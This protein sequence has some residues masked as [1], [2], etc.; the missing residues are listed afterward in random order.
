MTT[1]QIAEKNGWQAIDAKDP[2]M[3]SYS[4]IIEGSPARINVWSSLKRGTT[5]GTYLNHPK[6]GKT[7]LFRRWVSEKELVKIFENPRIH[8]GKGYR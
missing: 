8:S 6:Q 3:E 4:K 1:K 5:V 7:Q 2:Y